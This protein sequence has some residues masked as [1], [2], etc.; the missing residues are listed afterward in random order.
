MRHLLPWLTGVVSQYNRTIKYSWVTSHLRYIHLRNHNTNMSCLE[1]QRFPVVHA[2][3]LL[4][5][6]A[7]HFEGSHSILFV[8]I[9]SR[10]LITN[11][12]FLYLNNLAIDKRLATLTRS[13]LLVFLSFNACALLQ[14][15]RTQHTPT[16]GLVTGPALLPTSLP[17]FRQDM[18][19]NSGKASPDFFSNSQGEP[20]W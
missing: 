3:S 12:Y 18:E 20:A 8:K 5:S 11:Y 15:T 19:D 16:W 17:G 13:L 1:K 14:H 7:T 9:H 6:I 10:G 2:R 4:V